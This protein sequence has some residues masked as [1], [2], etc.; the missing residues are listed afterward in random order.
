MGSKTPLT[1]LFSALL[2]PFLHYFGEVLV[3]L[4]VLVVVD[5]GKT[6]S[7]PSLKFWT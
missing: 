5:R 3:V 1:L 6:K 4:V 2:T 7:T